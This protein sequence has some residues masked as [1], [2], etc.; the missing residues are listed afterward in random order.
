MLLRDKVNKNHIPGVSIS[1]SGTGAFPGSE[2]DEEM[3]KFLTSKNIPFK[4]HRSRD[5]TASQL[6]EA[7]IVLVM[8]EAHRD[9]ILNRWPQA[10]DKLQKLGR[11]IALDKTE[12]DIA[13][14]YG[15]SQYHYRAAQSQ[16]TL[17]VSNL[18]KVLF[19]DTGS[20]A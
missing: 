20:N 18:F 13:D 4:D 9:I 8:E 5:L 16:I 14:P 1:S 12:D 7:D 17:A 10:E 6:E 11:Y 2:A 19:Q 15:R 3:T